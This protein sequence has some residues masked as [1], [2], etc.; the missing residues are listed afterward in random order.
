MET[1]CRVRQTHAAV[2]AGQNHPGESK[3]ELRLRTCGRF[4]HAARS[5]PTRPHCCATSSGQDHFVEGNCEIDPG[6]LSRDCSYSSVIGLAS[7]GRHG[8]VAVDDLRDIS[9]I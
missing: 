3:H 1:T 7:G 9:L 2:S 4:A 8:F 6:K 5:R